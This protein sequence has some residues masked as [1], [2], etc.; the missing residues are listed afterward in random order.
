M[1]SRTSSIQVTR[2]CRCLSHTIQHIVYSAFAIRSTLHIIGCRLVNWI[3]IIILLQ[4]KNKNM[5]APG[6]SYLSVALAIVLASEQLQSI[7]NAQQTFVCGNTYQDASQNCTVNPSCPSGNAAQDCEPEGY[8]QC[9]VMPADA[10]FSPPTRAPVTDSPT[11][12]PIPA[13]LKVCAGSYEEAV[14]NCLTND[15]CDENSC[16]LGQACF[17]VA[18]DLCGTLAPTPEP[19]PSSYKVC[20]ANSFE[21]EANCLD[22][23]KRCPTGAA[24]ECGPTE[25]C[26]NVPANVCGVTQGPST[27]PMASGNSEETSVPTRLPT[28]AP[29]IMVVPTAPTMPPTPQFI[30]VCGTDP[31][32]AQM[33]ICTNP[34]CPTGDVSDS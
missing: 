8:K 25:A 26:F 12:S 6:R 1:Y 34:R 11:L 15:S 3:I 10:C 24:A 32:D 5:M 17:D 2:S 9:Y 21:S 33:N 30:A 13:P 16:A 18:V 28:S 7:V 22:M 20:G 31:N 4:P 29:T 23:S 14:E 19:T 27:S